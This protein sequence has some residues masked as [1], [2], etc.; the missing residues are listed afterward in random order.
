M[1]NESKLSS[2][3]LQ[4]PGPEDTQISRGCFCYAKLAKIQHEQQKE[5]KAK[6][7]NLQSEKTL[8]IRGD[9]V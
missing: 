4:E 8:L 1:F 6:P 3:L 2:F 7:N 5:L 9:L